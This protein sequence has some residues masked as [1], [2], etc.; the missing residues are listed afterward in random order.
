MSE[1]LEQPQGKGMAVG[2]FILALVG[3]VLCSVIAVIAAGMVLTGG[4]PWLMYVWTVMC[5]ASVIMCAMAMGKLKKSGQKRGL[6]IAG[7]VIGIVASTWSIILTLGL[8]V[9]DSELGDKT[10]QDEFSKSM[11]ELENM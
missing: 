8:G 11:K 4:S 2:G 3:L 1:N 6:A 7:L 9:A 10:I 5:I